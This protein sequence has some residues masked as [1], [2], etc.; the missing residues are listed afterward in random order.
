[1]NKVKHLY[2]RMSSSVIGSHACRSPL[3]M[4]SCLK[5]FTIPLLMLLCK[6]LWVPKT[7]PK[8]VMTLLLEK[9]PWQ[10]TFL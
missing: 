7:W 4:R 9:I 6:M 3:R 10:T 8:S 2:C 1:M 5:S